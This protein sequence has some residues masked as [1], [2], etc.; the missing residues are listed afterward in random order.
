MTSSKANFLFHST[1]CF[2][3]T[4]CIEGCP[5]DFNPQGWLFRPEEKNSEESPV[6][7]EAFFIPIRFSGRDALHHR[8]ICK[9]EKMK[10]SF[11]SA[12]Y[13]GVLVSTGIVGGMVSELRTLAA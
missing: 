3:S 12:T 2:Y 13:G 7:R 1:G 8:K 9:P 10:I 6:I 11:F 5:F 4:G